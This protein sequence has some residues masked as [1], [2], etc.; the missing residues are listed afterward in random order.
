MFTF[1]KTCFGTC[2]WNGHVDV[3]CVALCRDNF[4]RYKYFATNSTMFTFGKTCF[5]TCCI[6]GAIDSLGVAFSL[7]H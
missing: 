5:S 1:G 6:N 2:C 3:L 7:Y 4:L